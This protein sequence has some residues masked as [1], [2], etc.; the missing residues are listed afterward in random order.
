MPLKFSIQDC[1]FHNWSFLAPPALLL[2]NHWMKK[3]LYEHDHSSL[4]AVVKFQ[5]HPIVVIGLERIAK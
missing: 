1:Q 5:Y 3:I 2:Y 4:L